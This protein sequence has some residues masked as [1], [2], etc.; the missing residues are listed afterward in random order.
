MHTEEDDDDEDVGAHTG[1]AA[2]SIQTY[3]HIYIYTCIQKKMKTT[4]T[5]RSWAHTQ[6]RQLRG[7]S[8]KRARKKREKETMIQ[9]KRMGRALIKIS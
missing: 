6:V 2:K 9:I 3:I 8:A 5:T 7:H 1:A 4:M